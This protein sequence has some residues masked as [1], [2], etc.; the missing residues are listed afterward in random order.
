MFYWY[1]TKFKRTISFYPYLIQL[2]D[3]VTLFQ[4]AIKKDLSKVK[5]NNSALKM[6]KLF[7]PNQEKGDIL[8][9]IKEESR[10]FVKKFIHSFLLD[11]KLGVITR[12]TFVL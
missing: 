12:N 9:A 7:K 4:K 5:I 11:S 2:K 1:N 3:V 6:F 8:A 10:E